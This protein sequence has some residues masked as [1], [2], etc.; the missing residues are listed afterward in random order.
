MHTK[1]ETRTPNII[2]NPRANIR[3]CIVLSVSYSPP[4]GYT[5][6]TTEP[7]ILLR[8]HPAYTSTQK[9]HSNALNSLP[10][11]PTIMMEPNLAGWGLAL[12]FTSVPR[13]QIRC[14][15]PRSAMEL[16]V[17]KLMHKHTGRENRRSLTP[18]N[19]PTKRDRNRSGIPEH[20][21]FLIR[22]IPLRTN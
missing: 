14:L 3:N 6:T 10:A 1:N 2:R 20:H 9:V 19:Q 18:Q 21:Q 12:Q 11:A 16:P 13:A 17:H 22:P 5:Q 7:S 8:S 15:T 4:T